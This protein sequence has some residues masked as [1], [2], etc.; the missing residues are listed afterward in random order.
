MGVKNIKTIIGAPKK[1][2]WKEFAGKTVAIDANLFLHKWRH[3]AKKFDGTL[4]QFLFY[5]ICNLR[6]KEIIPV[7]IFDG[8]APD[9]KQEVLDKRKERERIDYNEVKQMLDVFSVP[10]LDAPGEAEAQAAHLTNI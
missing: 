4:L 2:Q 3:V 5:Q 10:Y 7:Y 8:K 6:K 1:K 9:L